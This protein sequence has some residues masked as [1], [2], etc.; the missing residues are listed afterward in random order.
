MNKKQMILKMAVAIFL[1]ATVATG[2]KNSS[3]KEESSSANDE[4]KGSELAVLMQAPMTP[5]AITRDHATKVIVNITVVEHVKKLADSTDYMFWVFVVG[6]AKLGNG[7]CSSCEGAGD[8][9][10]VPDRC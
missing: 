8:G 5:P 10:W 7:C 2:C 1:T 9:N 4:I 6:G 3:A